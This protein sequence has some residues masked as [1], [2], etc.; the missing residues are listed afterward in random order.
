M[1]TRRRPPRPA[2]PQEVRVVTDSTACLPAHLPGGPAVVPLRVL[3]GADVYAE[4]SD[5]TPER[6]AE[7]VADGERVTTSQPPPAAFATTYRGL[8][9]QGALSIASAQ[10]AGR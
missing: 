10:P 7:L 2:A 4:G 5:I 6:L 3:V 1:R 9:E 8:A